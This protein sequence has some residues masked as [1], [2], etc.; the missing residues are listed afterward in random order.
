MAA[1]PQAARDPGTPM[2]TDAQ[3]RRESGRGKHPRPV[4]P[5]ATAADAYSHRFMAWFATGLIETELP[6]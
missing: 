6:Q 2:H 4:K 1:V 3:R 5:S